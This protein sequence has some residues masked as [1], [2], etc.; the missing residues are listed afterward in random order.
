MK[1]SNKKAFFWMLEKA[2]TRKFSIIFLILIYAVLAVLGVSMSVFS[3]N[4]IDSA[5]SGDVS[6][7]FIFALIITLSALGVI[8]LNLLCRVLVFNIDAKL[9][10]T[11]KTELFKKIMD[12]NFSDITKYHSGEVLNRLTADVSVVTGTITTFFAQ[13][14]FLILKLAGVFTVLFF[15]DWQF[16]LVF[17]V[18]GILIFSVTQFF[19]KRM[20]NLHKAVQETDGKVKSFLQE[21]VE[22]MLVVKV[23]NAGKKVVNNAFN[24]QQ[25]NYKEKRKR[26]YISIFATTGFSLVFTFGYF[27]AM[28][29]GAYGIFSGELT[30]GSLTAVLSLVSQIQGPISSLSGIIPQ[31][32]SAL[33]SAERIMEIANLPDEPISENTLPVGTLYEKMSAVCF[34]HI[35][36]GYTDENVFEDASLTVN[37][38]DYVVVTGI[39]GI[40]KSTLTRLL[41]CVYKPCKGSIYLSLSDGG[42]VNVDGSLRRMFA[43]VPQGNFLLSGTIRENIAFMRPDATDDEIMEAAKISCAYDFISKLPNGLDTKIGEKGN[44]LSEGQVQRIA[45]ARALICNS[46]VLILDEATSALDENTEMQL[47]NNLKNYR[48]DI[49]CILISHKTAAFK[50]CNKEVKIKDKK[51][52]IS[53]IANG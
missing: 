21:T 52:I 7:I 17:L 39:S 51:I 36:F 43:Y 33:A 1:N 26:N 16:A 47:L 2:S 53:E 12:K 46:P 8:L 45:I 40:G 24:L 38:G 14:S 32:Y 27:F 11:I 29:W 3:K 35:T 49:T 42:R 23:F 20:K 5:V 28:I 18:G 50:I 34:D 37:K 41:L 31:Y 10:I 44:G 25:E 6:G 19:K 13:I 15:I 22:S 48:S 30:Y 9:E 4:L